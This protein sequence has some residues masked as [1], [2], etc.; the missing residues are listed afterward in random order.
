MTIMST[1]WCTSLQDGMESTLAEHS[2]DEHATEEARPLQAP[3]TEA[4]CL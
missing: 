1:T 4:E 3:I 2:Y